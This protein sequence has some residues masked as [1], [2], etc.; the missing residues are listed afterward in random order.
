MCV[1]YCKLTVLYV[2]RKLLYA[3]LCVYGVY[4]M[5]AAER[6]GGRAAAACVAISDILMER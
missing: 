2:E 3:C 6:S 1:L 4:D 5:V